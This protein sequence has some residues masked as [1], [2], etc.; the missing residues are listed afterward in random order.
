MVVYGCGENLHSLINFLRKN[1]AKALLFLTNWESPKQFPNIRQ[2]SSRQAYPL[3]PENLDVTPTVSKYV[4]HL[5]F[6]YISN[7]QQDFLKEGVVTIISNIG[8][9]IGSLVTLLTK[10]PEFSSRQWMPSF[11]KKSIACNKHR[12]HGDEKK[13]NFN[14]EK[15]SLRK[16]LPYLFLEQRY[17][18]INLD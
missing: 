9:G 13:T 11:S 7:L 15:Q 3:V 1:C 6:N 5:D 14:F 16:P 18:V 17:K 12:K 8:W 4:K 2:I 10:V